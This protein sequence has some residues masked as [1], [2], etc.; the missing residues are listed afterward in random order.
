MNFFRGKKNTG[1][2]NKRTKFYGTFYYLR[3]ARKILCRFSQNILNI[4]RGLNKIEVRASP[5]M[6]KI[7]NG[8]ESM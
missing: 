5:R 6:E 4:L 3:V 7:S 8:G 1:R 2:T